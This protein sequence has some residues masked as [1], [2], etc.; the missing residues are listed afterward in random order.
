MKDAT[1]KGYFFFCRS[2]EDSSVTF[3]L[4]TAKSLC[5]VRSK[6]FCNFKGERI[7]QSSE[8]RASSPFTF[9]TLLALM[10]LT[11]RVKTKK[12]SAVRIAA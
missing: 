6:G 10:F 7:D 2:E 9:P 1:V 4:Q 8:P 12:L 5:P 3:F 11:R